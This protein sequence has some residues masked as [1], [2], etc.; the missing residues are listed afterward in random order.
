MLQRGCRPEA[1]AYLVSVS[2]DA[3]DH[4]DVV[5]FHAALQ[6]GEGV[7]PAFLRFVEVFVQF[8]LGDA[9]QA[10]ARSPAEHS[11]DVFVHDVVVH[12]YR[13]GEFVYLLVRREGG[14]GEFGLS[15]VFRGLERRHPSGARGGGVFL[16]RA[17]PVREP[18][19]ERGGL[20]IFA[21]LRQ[22]VHNCKGSGVHVRRNGEFVFLLQHEEQIRNRNPLGLRR[23]FWCRERGS[24]PH[25][26][27]PTGF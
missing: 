13:E 10:Y 12:V 15:F 6:Q 8:A 21:L 22:W 4:E 16:P 2:P 17:S 27:A 9:F 24:N 11:L 19:G 1:R 3:V 5:F 18:G 26:L 7:A 23:L 25:G 14:R 20:W